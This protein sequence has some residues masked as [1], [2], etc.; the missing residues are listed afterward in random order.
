M[1]P[2]GVLHPSCVT[3]P[4]PRRRAHGDWY[5]RCSPLPRLVLLFHCFCLPFFTSLTH[6]NRTAPAPSQV[7]AQ[8]VLLRRSSGA[9]V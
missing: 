4:L 7:R 8:S 5:R 9:G 6:F 3:H 1:S 2:T